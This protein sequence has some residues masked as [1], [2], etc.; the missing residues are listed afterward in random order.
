[1]SAY[2]CKLDKWGG[3]GD[4]LPLPVQ[5]S[6]APVCP[7]T[8]HTVHK[9]GDGAIVIHG[10]PPVAGDAVI[11]WSLPGAE[12]AEWYKFLALYSAANR[13][14]TDLTF[15]GYWGDKFEV[16]CLRAMDV[17]ARGKVFDLS[18]EFQIVSVTSWGTAE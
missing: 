9:T 15:E 3:S 6:Y 8:R 14:T 11:I 18:G 13:V 4:L 17:T 12:R 2:F 1:M 5:F 7:A 10:N 16:R